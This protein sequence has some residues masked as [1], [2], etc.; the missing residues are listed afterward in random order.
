[1]PPRFRKPPLPKGIARYLAYRKMI[2]ANCYM[3]RVQINPKLRNRKGRGR[4]PETICAIRSEYD[5]GG[6]RKRGPH[7]RGSVTQKTLAAKY[8]MSKSAIS[9]ILSDIT[10]TD[11]KFYP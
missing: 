8:G 1:M 6:N 5:A 10:Y 3:L 4:S 9:L 7:A 2:Y 11:D